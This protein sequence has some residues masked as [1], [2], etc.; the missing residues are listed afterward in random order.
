MNIKHQTPNTKHQERSKH[1][2]SNG[3]YKR[4]DVRNLVFFSGLV[5]G[6]W[7]FCA[8]FPSSATAAQRKDKPGSEKIPL[9]PEQAETNYTQ[10]IEKRAADILADLKLNDAA[11]SARV[12]DAITNQYRA[13]RDWQATYQNKR[14]T[15]GPQ[16]GEVVAALAARQALHD[17]FITRLSTD[18]TPDKLEKVKDRMTYNKVKVTYDGY[19]EIMPNLTAEQKAKVLELLKQAREEAMDGVSAEEKSAI[20]RKY[21]GKINVYLSAQ[22]LDVGQAYKD[23]GEKQKAKSGAK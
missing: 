4:I 12:H 23:W 8:L 3:H 19:C 9:P 5:L 1:Q 22:G 17:K 21:K 14:G 18:L 6:V 2:A 13:L 7:C 10:T 11:K 20:F 15:A 16:S